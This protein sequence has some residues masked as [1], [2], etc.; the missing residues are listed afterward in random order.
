MTR[1]ISSYFHCR[2]CIESIPEGT[3]P[4]EWADLSVGFTDRG[5]QVVC[6]R[7]EL[8]VVHIDFEGQRHPADTG[9]TGDFA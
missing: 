7:H 1:Y 2:Q 3:T 4:Q 8:N 5:L 6:N 9:N